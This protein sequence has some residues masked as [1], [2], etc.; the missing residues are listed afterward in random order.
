MMKILRVMERSVSGEMRIVSES[1]S[2]P[3]ARNCNIIEDRGVGDEIW[4]Q[5]V[6]LLM[7]WGPGCQRRTR[8]VEL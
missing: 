6:A 2:V 5:E 3:P 7:R 4:S 8:K 1:L